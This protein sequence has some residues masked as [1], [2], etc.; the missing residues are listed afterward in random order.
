[1]IEAWTE[2][3]DRYPQQP[4]AAEAATYA[5]DYA[6]VLVQ[7]APDHPR[8]DSVYAEA[9]RVLF[10][11]YDESEAATKHRLFY[12]FRV[13]QQEGQHERAAVEYARVPFGHPQYFE[14][15]RLR[16]FNLQRVYEETPPDA[17]DTNSGR[18]FRE[19]KRRIANGAAE[20]LAG[21][22]RRAMEQAGTMAEELAAGNA[23]GTAMV[24]LAA[25]AAD[26]DE[27][28]AALR[29]LDEAQQALGDA[30]VY[31]EARREVLTRRILVLV[32]AG[33][34]E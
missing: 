26:A 2:V 20:Q 5:A 4:L 12:A 25:G 22:A 16:L 34:Y 9:M 13:F 6:T 30:A 14:A 28:D 1:A 32:G 24:A 7:Q 19:A 33:R 15:Q 8:S 3:A 11:R 18:P 21:D 10:T 17:M 29:F 23:Y 27:T 31:D